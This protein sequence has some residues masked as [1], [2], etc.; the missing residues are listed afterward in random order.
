MVQNQINSLL[1]KVNNMVN[2]LQG[3]AEADRRRVTQLER[4]LESRLEEKAREGDGREKWAEIQG[5]VKGLIEETQALTRRVE[6]LDERLWARTSGSEIAKQR[7]RELEQQVQNLEQQSRLISAATEE[8]QKR[9]ATKIRR[10]EHSLEEATR[11]LVKVEEEAR[12][13]HGGHQQN[14]LDSRVAQVEQQQEQLDAELR[15][16]QMQVDEAYAVSAEGALHPG[17]NSHEP[18]LDEAIQAAE[19][20]L[21]TLEKKVSTQI[22]DLASSVA[23]LRVKVDGHH[24]RVGT[25]AERMETAH[26]PAMESLHQELTQGTQQHR[27]E[28]DSELAALKTRLQE[29][30]DANEEALTELREA[31][32]HA[33]AEIAAFSLRPDDSPVLHAFDERLT[34]NER[35]LCDIQNRIDTLPL[36]EEGGRGSEEEGEKLPIPEEIDDLRRRIEWLEEQGAAESASG[37]ADHQRQA[38]HHQNAICDLVEQVSRL[39]HQASNSEAASSSMQQQVSQLQGALQRHHGDDPLA[40][41]IEKV[42]GKVD[43][44][45]QQVADMAA[46]LL[47]VEGGLDFAREHETSPLGEVS[48]VSAHSEL[49]SGAPPRGVPPLPRPH[50]SDREH[51]PDQNS[52]QMLVLQ[53]KLQ[54]VAEHLELQDDLETRVADL[55]RRLEGLSTSSGQHLLEKGGEVSFGTEATVPRGADTSHARSL[56]HPHVDEMQQDIHDLRAR[57]TAAEGRLA[58]A[59]SSPEPGQHKLKKCKNCGGSGIDFAGKPCNCA[60]CDKKVCEDCN[61]TGKDFTGKP[62]TRCEASSEA[63]KH[64]AAMDSFSERLEALEQELQASNEAAHLKHESVQ[65]LHG[66]LQDLTKK[67]SKTL[68]DLDNVKESHAKTDAAMQEHARAANHASSSVTDLQ[69]QLKKLNANTHSNGKSSALEGLEELKQDIDAIHAKLRDA[70]KNSKDSTDKDRQELHHDLEKRLNEIEER[71]PEDDVNEQV[72]AHVQRHLKAVHEK[73]ESMDEMS[74]Q[75]KEDLEEVQSQ[76]KSLADRIAAAELPKPHGH[77]DSKDTQ[78]LKEKLQALS[79]RLAAA[80][81]ANSSGHKL[82]PD[83]ADRLQGIEERLNQNSVVDP[84]QASDEEERLQ[85][86]KKLEE[87]RT[88]MDEEL[89]HLDNHHKDLASTKASLQ[90][91]SEQVAAVGEPPSQKHM[92]DVLGR[93]EHIEKNAGKNESSSDNKELKRLSEMVDAL[94][95]HKADTEDALSKIHEH[96]QKLSD[97]QEESRT[98]ALPDQGN[99]LPMP[100]D[101][102]DLSTRI[103]LLEDRHEA[104]LPK[105]P[106]KQDKDS[107]DTPEEKEKDENMRLQVQ[108]KLREMSAQMS[109]E[110]SSLAEHQQDVVGMR[111]NLETLSEKMSK[112]GQPQDN[113]S[114]PQAEV[115][116]LTSRLK[117]LEQ[118]LESSGLDHIKNDLKQAKDSLDTLNSHT[119]KFDRRLQVHE[120]TAVALKRDIDQIKGPVKVGIGLAG[121]GG[122]SLGEMQR[123]L[124]ELKD[125]IADANSGRKVKPTVS[126]HLPEA[127][128]NFS[129]TEQTEC[130]EAPHGEGSLNFSLTESRKDLSFSEPLAGNSRRGGGSA[131]TAGTA[132]GPSTRGSRGS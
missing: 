112:V 52:Q 114:P 21:A 70:E 68:S 91:L 127:S 66:Q 117:A 82:P 125:Q 132:T 64:A 16:L 18:R 98:R 41:A 118:K 22:E 71:L 108:E 75:H 107:G 5:S 46:R 50:G 96:I 51:A 74:D 38:A 126:E 72:Q 40:R 10:V 56:P 23:T 34:A 124:N 119:S 49:A 43:A 14:F 116:S 90:A 80:E 54:E 29:T 93:L 85:V 99:A 130:A 55:E 20:G 97:E 84:K 131:T 120:D 105:S 53:E 106:V 65:D 102:K 31:L 19:H 59:H 73:L 128:L 109:K 7:N 32:R 81:V 92:Q 12:A 17:E 47:E 113:A 28:L 78:D 48:A 58:D 45:S 63:A 121:G 44:V 104:S 67:F 26:K 9:Q 62:C 89:G 37:H 86:G 39:K 2:S 36:P 101:I 110:I 6:G 77:E 123:Q 103:K 24:Q 83:V 1:D 129:L 87:L 100:E 88:K 94:H 3:Q 122:L 33:H 4:R 30:V 27:R 79:E 115:D 61:N 35:D 95:G 8:T 69:E 57:I 25:L 11:R 42:E 76:L 15:Q 111:T 60:A 13:R